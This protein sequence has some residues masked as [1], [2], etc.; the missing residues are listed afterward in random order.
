MNMMHSLW[1]SKNSFKKGSADS[2]ERFTAS[3]LLEL[4]Y[5]IFIR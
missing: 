4:L 1:K 5:L 2:C 3:A